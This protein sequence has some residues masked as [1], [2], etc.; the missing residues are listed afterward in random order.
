MKILI[1]ILC[2]VCLFEVDAKD[3]PKDVRAD[4]EDGRTRQSDTGV[5]DS[6]EF[7]GN[8]RRSRYGFGGAGR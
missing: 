4:P 1:S 8:R 7:G 2:V 3:F 5:I 6:R